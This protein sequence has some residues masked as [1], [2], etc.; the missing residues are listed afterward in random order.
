MNSK[1]QGWLHWSLWS[2]WTFCDV[3]FMSWRQTRYGRTDGWLGP[4]LNV[5]ALIQT[6]RP[7][8]DNVLPSTCKLILLTTVAYDLLITSRNEFIAVVDHFLKVPNLTFHNSNAKCNSLTLILIPLL[9]SN[10]FVSPTSRHKLIRRPTLNRNPYL[11]NS[12]FSQMRRFKESNNRRL[13]YAINTLAWQLRHTTHVSTAVSCQPL[14]QDHRSVREQ[15]RRPLFN[16][17]N[18][19][20]LIII[21][22]DHDH[23]PNS[24]S[25]PYG[26]EQNCSSNLTFKFKPRLWRNTMLVEVAGTAID[27]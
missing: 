15:S 18:F 10:P 4:I 8:L 26:P 5:P 20:N 27:R 21:N 3:W 25:K 23:I 14:L 24:N 17:A 16:S 1:W 9:M 13:L 7:E 2:L 12:S 19:I 11:I 6:G 22:P